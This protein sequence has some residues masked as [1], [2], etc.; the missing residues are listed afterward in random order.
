MIVF[1]CH[2]GKKAKNEYTPVMFTGNK[3]TYTVVFD[4][5][6]WLYT[7]F[8]SNGFAENNKQQIQMI[9][10]TWA[11]LNENETILLFYLICIDLAH[12]K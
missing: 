4:K 12:V 5:D 2:S 6:D 11:E 9:S 8:L 7:S 1:M 3:P 10:F